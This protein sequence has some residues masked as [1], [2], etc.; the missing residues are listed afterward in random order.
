MEGCQ[1]NKFIKEMPKKVN[2]KASKESLSDDTDYGSCS[3][4][5]LGPKVKIVTDERWPE[6]AMRMSSG[7]MLSTCETASSLDPCR[8]I[9]SSQSQRPSSCDSLRSEDDANS[10]MSSEEYQP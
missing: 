2:I 9:V 6:E 4:G 3:F 5:N 1:L 10:C 7:P 8:G